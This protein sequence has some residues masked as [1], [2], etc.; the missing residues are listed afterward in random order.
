MAFSG[1]GNSPMRLSVFT[2]SLLF[3][4][5]HL[6]IAALVPLFDDEAYYA[7]WARDLAPGYYDHPPMIAYMIRMGTNLF[8]ETAL[9]IR[10]FSVIGFV[11]SG[12]LVGD[13]ARRMSG[14]VVGLPVLATTLYNSNVLVFA[15]GSFATP[16][17]PSTLFWV[18][19]LWAAIRAVNTPPDNRLAM[20]WWVC[21]GLFIGLG[22]LSKFTNAFLAVGLLAYLIA[23]PKG[24]AYLLTGLPYMSVIVAVL[25]LL[26]YIFWN[27]QNDWLGLE[28]QGARLDASGFSLR[29]LGE[30]AALLLL[31]PT[32]LVTWFAFRALKAPPKDCMLL[33]WSSVPLLLY[34]AYHATHSQVQANW[35]V[36]LQALFAIPAA[37]GLAQA[38]SRRLLS[39]ATPAIALLTSVGLVAIVFNPFTP[40]G[41]TNNP[42]NQTRGWSATEDAIAEVLEETGARWIATTD[43]ARTG[44]LALR[45]PHLP[46]WSV[47]ELQRYGFRGAFPNELCKAPGLLIERTRRSETTSET[48]LG[49]FE[50]VQATRTAMRTQDGVTLMLFQLTPVS[51]VAVAELCPN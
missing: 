13:I 22:G 40:I 26:P 39:K 25:P 41:T 9:G 20:L 23:T 10:L 47:T 27:L 34:F 35:I 38:Q 21:T 7:L 50:T 37:F 11:V 42:P 51:G 4:A 2:V 48:A 33:I 49:F 5:I 28:R 46:V 44:S 36:P 45:F 29:Y 15:L 19:A 18:A 24:R 3:L 14:G 32:P 43:Y 8:G 6:A 17:A 16:D 12:Y 31:A 30:Y 1:E